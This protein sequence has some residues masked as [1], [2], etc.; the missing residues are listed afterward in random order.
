MTVTSEIESKN[1]P[2]SIGGSLAPRSENKIGG[3]R[4]NEKLSDIM[5]LLAPRIACN[6][7][8]RS[9]TD[10]IHQASERVTR[11]QV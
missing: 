1:E 4:T 2:K 3:P 6:R 10:E 5:S 11:S 7:M 9:R 8:A